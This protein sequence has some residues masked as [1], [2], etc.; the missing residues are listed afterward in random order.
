MDAHDDDNPEDDESLLGRVEIDM[1]ELIRVGEMT[2]AFDLD[3]EGGTRGPKNETRAEI[4]LSITWEATSRAD[5]EVKHSFAVYSAIQEGRWRKVKTM[6][7]AQVEAERLGQARALVL[8]VQNEAEILVDE[9][10]AR[11]AAAG[12][13]A[14][15]LEKRD[16]EGILDKRVMEARERAASAA[17]ADSARAQKQSGIKT[18]QRKEIRTQPNYTAASTRNRLPSPDS[19]K[20][21]KAAQRKD[22]MQRDTMVRIE[23]A[24]KRLKAW[25]DGH[26]PEN[27]EICTTPFSLVNKWTHRCKSCCKVV[28]SKCSSHSGLTGLSV[29]KRKLCDDCYKLPDKARL[30]ALPM[31]RRNKK[32]GPVEAA[33]VT[34]CE[35]CWKQFDF[36]TWHHQCNLCFREVCHLCSENKLPISGLALTLT[37]PYLRSLSRLGRSET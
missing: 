7:L 15:E 37:P 8:S 17:R 26:I 16:P 12:Q 28:C 24:Q 29:R 9:M 10:A 6:L 2:G 18:E 27:C 19:P 5:M 32:L 20:S 33:Q 22:R 36:K 11:M 4:F 31:E 3:F 14:A 23:T 1:V 25:R 13:A 34:E 30:V 35:V 21:D